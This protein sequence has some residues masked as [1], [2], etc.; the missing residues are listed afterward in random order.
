MANAVDSVRRRSGVLLCVS[1]EDWGLQQRYR[2]SS[3]GLD[4][5]E[6]VA[7]RPKGG[8]RAHRSN[9]RPADLVCD[10]F[11]APFVPASEI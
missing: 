2:R 5:C 9:W 8:R 1:R 7:Q 10:P 3:D 4:G 11:S 6:D